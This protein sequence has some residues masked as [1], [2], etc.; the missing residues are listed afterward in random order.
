MP[1]APRGADRYAPE[2]YTAAVEALRQ[3]HEAVAQRDYRLALNHA[4][5]SRERAQAAAKKA[6][7]QQAT[8]RSAAER[9]LG[10][11]TAMLAAAN[12]Q[13]RAAEAARVPRRALAAPRAEI[14]SADEALQK[15]GA[16]LTTGDYRESQ[17]QLD[18]TAGRLSRV[19]QE[20]RAATGARPAR[21]RR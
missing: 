15:A 16:A 2:E 4:L 8:L 20:L 10:E 19:T 14:A 1:R 7:D 5:D 18:E 12:Q 6:A 13:L 3:A 21:G 11:V 17:A 9:R